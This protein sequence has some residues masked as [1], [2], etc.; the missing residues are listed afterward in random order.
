MA[1]K[2]VAL[3]TCIT[4]IFTIAIFTPESNAG[5][6]TLNL[7]KQTK[8]IKVGESFQLTMTGVKTSSI[9]WKS[10]KPGVA[11]VNKK[12]VV[13]GIKAGTTNITGKYKSLKFVIK[14]TVKSINKKTDK[15]TESTTESTTENSTEQTSDKMIFISENNDVAVYYGGQ[16]KSEANIYYFKFWIKNKT[17]KTMYAS[18]DYVCADGVSINDVNS[19]QIYSGK[20]NYIEICSEKKM[21]ESEIIGTL[22]YNFPRNNDNENRYLE[23]KYTK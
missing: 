20:T 10:S 4:I 2:I 22:Y 13:K 19:T 12:G 21:G 14:V 16:N 17:D 18:I 3:L 11:T 5:L 1:K 15:T 7:S 6:Q 23:F 9:K 8:E